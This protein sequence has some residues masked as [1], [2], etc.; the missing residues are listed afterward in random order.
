MR[1]KLTTILL[2]L[3]CAVGTASAIADWVPSEQYCRFC[4]NFKFDHAF[5]FSSS[6]GKRSERYVSYRYP[7]Y[8]PR[9]SRFVG[10]QL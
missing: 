1:Q 5:T 9:A 6:D 3:F 8:R 2:A 4:N 7:F 10:E